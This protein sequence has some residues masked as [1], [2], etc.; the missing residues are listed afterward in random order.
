MEESKLHSTSWP[1]HIP[2]GREE[3]RKAFQ[4]HYLKGLA[5]SALLHCLILGSYYFNLYLDT[6]KE[7]PMVRVR[8][9]NYSQLGPPPSISSVHIPPAV[10]V[11][12]TAKP[13]V[14]IPVPVPDAEVSS[15]QTIATQEEMSMNPSPALEDFAS[16][17]QIEVT[18]DI[19]INEDE[20]G[21]N[22]FIPVERPPQI[23]KKAM[24]EYPELAVRAELEGVVWVKILV[25][26]EG[27]PQK[28]VVVK[29][30][31]EIFNAPA[32]AAAMQYL[33]TPAYMN[34]GPV[35][36]WVAVSFRFQLKDANVP[37]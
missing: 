31:S 32:V 20:P 24:P 5:V 22:E 3:L 23:V 19:V 18:G 15:E 21:L 6:K 13:S 37:S 25:D 11:A 12:A 33:F 27:K 14:G 36:I 17:E 30:S 2:Y 16:G 4:K 7:I 1:G 9:L 34:Q 8:V 29:S 35:K 10:R 28:V 26:R